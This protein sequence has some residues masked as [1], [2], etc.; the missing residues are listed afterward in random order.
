MAFAIPPRSTPGVGGF[1]RQG[2]NDLEAYW[3]ENMRIDRDGTYRPRWGSKCLYVFGGT[4][5]HLSRIGG[6]NARLA[7][8]ANSGTLYDIHVETLSPTSLGTSWPTTP[9]ASCIGV[10]ASGTNLWLACKAAVGGTSGSLYKYDGT[11]L[12]AIS[13]PGN[14]NFVGMHGYFAVKL[15]SGVGDNTAMRWS[16]LGNA[17]TWP[18]TSAKQPVPEI[19]TVDAI[20]PFSL[21]ESLL[22]G[23]GGVATMSGTSASGMSFSPV[24]NTPVA[25]PMHHVVKCRDAVYFLAPGPAICRY[26]HP[27]VVERIEAPLERLLYDADGVTNL[28]AWYDPQL[29][30]YVLWDKTSH[31]GYHFSIDSQRWVGVTTFATTS[32]DC[33][34]YAEIDQGA[35]AVDA[36]DMPW[37]KGF[38]GAGA[39]LMQHDPSVY[40]D[41][42]TTSNTDRSSYVVAV[43]TKPSTGIDASLEKQCREVHLDG[44][45]S[46]TVKLKTRTGPD[47]SWTTTTLG[48][49]TAPGKVCPSLANMPAYTERVVRCETV[50]ASGVRWRS[51][52]IDE[53]P[54]GEPPVR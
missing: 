27:G 39:R 47:G 42:T 9:M 41:Q 23:P 14:G 33:I 5:T 43:E 46:W 21:R 18:V 36:A 20:V 19:G 13:S 1:A 32:V 12:T 4:I 31:C 45:G 28:R 53:V 29:N 38:F 26:R 15:L 52:S 25:T 49:V 30:H 16:D 50:S 3:L 2:S 34:G 7:V 37:G 40:T 22:F 54:V 8:V 48:T 6:Y 24:V 44:T 11:T 10:A 51:V 35:S 17:D